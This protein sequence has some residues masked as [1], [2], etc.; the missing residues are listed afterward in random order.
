MKAF[1]LYFVMLLHIV[2]PE[3]FSVNE[4]ASF[5]FRY[6]LVNSPDLGD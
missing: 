2:L 6:S 3:N 4:R 5:F 1:M